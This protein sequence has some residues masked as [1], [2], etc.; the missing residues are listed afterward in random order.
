MVEIIFAYSILIGFFLLETF[1]RQG[2]P[3]RSFEKTESDRNSTYLIGLTFFVILI[4]SIILNLL[5]IGTFRNKWLALSGLI[6]MGV[7]LIIRIYSMLTLNKFYTRTLI[8]TDAH[9]LVKTGLY[10]YIRHPG[11]FGTILIWCACG[12]AMQ[13]KIIF[14]AAII[15]T[16][17]A[18]YYRIE[19]EEKMMTEKFGQGYLEYKKHSWRLLPFL[20]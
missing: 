12:L 11:Y 13:N 9:E 1:L 20:W 7:G 8:L 18:Y 4:L 17:I 16:S 15:L 14:V 5:K 10:R 2:T 6:I 3:A 19:N